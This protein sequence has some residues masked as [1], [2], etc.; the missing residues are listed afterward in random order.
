MA[1]LEESRSNLLLENRQLMENVSSL[2]LRLQNL[3]T[4]ASAHSSDGLMKVCFLNLVCGD[5]PKVM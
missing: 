2:Q 5:F 1:G 4:S 3:E